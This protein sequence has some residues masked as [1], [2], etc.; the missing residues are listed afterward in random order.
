MEIIE[1]LY[2]ANDTDLKDNRRLEYQ[3]YALT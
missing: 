2:L 3:R 1:N